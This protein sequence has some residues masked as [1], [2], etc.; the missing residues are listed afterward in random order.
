MLSSH[1]HVTYTRG[2]KINNIITNEHNSLEKYTSHTL[3]EMVAKGLCVRGELETEQT[4]TY[5]PLVP[6]SLAALLVLLGCSIGGPE[7]P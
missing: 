5:L 1:K 3:F 7:G 4:A 6:L 2:N